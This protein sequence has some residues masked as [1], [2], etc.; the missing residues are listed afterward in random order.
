MFTLL[1]EA[2]NISA[3]MTSETVRAGRL[4]LTKSVQVG[5]SFV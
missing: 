1:P 3:T 2:D 5:Q 4:R